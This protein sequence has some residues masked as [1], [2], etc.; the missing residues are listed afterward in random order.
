[1]GG[2]FRSLKEEGEEEGLRVDGEGD[3]IV[4]DDDEGS[5]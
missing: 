4:F 1:M 5:S 2:I 3:G